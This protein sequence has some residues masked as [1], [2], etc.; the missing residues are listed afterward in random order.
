MVKPSE[1][2]LARMS[3]LAL[4]LQLLRDDD[5]PA[6]AEADRLE[7][8][9]KE[10]LSPEELQRIY[11]C[12]QAQLDEMDALEAIYTDT[13]TLRLAHAS[14]VDDLRHLLEELQ[15]LQKQHDGTDAAAVNIAL[16]AVADHPLLMFTLQLT[17]PIEYDGNGGDGDNAR[18]LVA[19]ILL[20]VSLPRHY[21]DPNAP[22]ALSFRYCVVTDR[23]E[24]CGLD[25][26]LASVAHLDETALRDQLLMGA[27]DLLPD[28]CL[29]EMAATSLPDAI[30]AQLR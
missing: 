2:A 14:R 21:P 22:P 16:R 7:P 5:A 8:Q 12:R 9:E 11:E 29:Y 6:V 17:I 3:E 30:A 24:E 10:V 15:M 23:R 25:K 27:A 4:R 18:E 28:P 20:H 1:Q 19:S 13:D 26:P